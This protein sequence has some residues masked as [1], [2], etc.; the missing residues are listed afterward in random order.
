MQWTMLRI[1][2][3]LLFLLFGAAAVVQYNDPDPLL[4]MSVY[5]AGALCC[6]LH[7]V[8]RLPAILAGCV[9][10]LCGLGALLLLGDILL[11]SGSFFDETGMEMMGLLEE[12]RELF[13]FS[14]TAAWTGVLTWRTRKAE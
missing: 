13:G 10:G 9:A 7:L 1:L 8:G 5:G 11:S 2:N 6:A 3:G 14:I 12:T 4:W